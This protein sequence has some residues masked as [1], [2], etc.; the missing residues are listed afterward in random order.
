MN[1]PFIYVA[2]FT[3]KSGKIEECRKKL[4]EL[5]DL[6]EANEPRMIAFNVYFDDA[7]DKV[8]V[9]QVH[10]DAASMQFHLTVIAEHLY[11]AG[12]YLDRTVGVD[13][14]GTPP[15]GLVEGDREWVAPDALRFMPVHEAGF[16]RT[17]AR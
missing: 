13:I 6:V 2:M 16:T 17:S 12:E 11:S 10:P 4:N 7:G 15:D 3:V 14:F 9:V 8:S 1:G 5:V